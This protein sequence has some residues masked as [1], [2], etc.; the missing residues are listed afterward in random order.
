[1]FR[2]C[3]SLKPI[4]LSIRGQNAF[5]GYFNDPVKEEELYDPCELIKTVDYI[6]GKNILIHIGTN[7]P[8]L[9]ET[10]KPRKF[11]RKRLTR[12]INGRNM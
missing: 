3:T 6:E 9:K 11:L 12:M 8:S 2:I 1:M 4:E 10:I 5:N 7:D